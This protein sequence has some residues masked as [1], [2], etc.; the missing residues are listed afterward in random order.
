M[1]D[2][3]D[4]TE[5]RLETQFRVERLIA[6]YALVIDED[7][8]EDWPELFTDDCLYQLI[9][10]ENADRGLPIAAIFCDSKAMLIDRVVSLRNAN[11]YEK[12][13]YRHIVSGIHIDNIADDT[14]YVRS[15]F[16]VYRTRTSGITEV[17]SAGIYHDEIVSNDGEFLFRSKRAIFDTN[18]ID[19]LLA[20]P[21]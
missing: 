8:L 18:V 12:H 4:E 21:I 9:A 5:L 14:I 16:V 7:A 3:L 15:N 11:I 17:Y 13:N 20:T 10:R 19:S 2:S 1:V 6:R